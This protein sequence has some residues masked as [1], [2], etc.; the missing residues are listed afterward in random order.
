MR[1]KFRPNPEWDDAMPNLTRDHQAQQSQDQE[2]FKTRFRSGSKALRPGGCDDCGA[3]Y[4]HCMENAPPPPYNSGGVYLS[5]AEEEQ[6]RMA[7]REAVP[8]TVLE[9]AAIEDGLAAEAY[10]VGSR[11]DVAEALAQ[12]NVNLPAHYARFKIEPIRFLIENRANP[13]QFN[14]VKYAMR[15]DAKNGL[16]DIRKI[17]RYAEMW[18]DFKSGDPDWW[19]PRGAPQRRPHDATPA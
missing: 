17:I 5:P 11:A 10:G 4:C 16:E 15:E 9:L 12:D 6:V 2:P 7:E 19:M 3:N 8:L 13:F 14:I 1:P 18:H